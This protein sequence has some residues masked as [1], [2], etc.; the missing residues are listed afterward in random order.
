MQLQEILSKVADFQKATDQPV[1]RVPMLSDNYQEDLLRYDLMKEE[2]KEYI[3]ACQNRDKV[4]ILDAAVDMLYILAGTINQHGLQNVI[5]TAFNRVHENNLT[6]IGPDGKVLRNPSGK[7]LK[8][9][10]FVPVSLDDLVKE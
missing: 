4:E 3:V 10:G 1:R 7:I 9:S 8:P 2:N 6:K 5:E